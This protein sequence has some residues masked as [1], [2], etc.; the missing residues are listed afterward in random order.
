[1][2]T[3]KTFEQRDFEHIHWISHLNYLDPNADV[4]DCT[5]Q[6]KRKENI[7]ANIIIDHC[8]C[9]SFNL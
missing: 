9:S 6:G 5:A 8:R 4:R 3:I 7:Q 2:C 1:M